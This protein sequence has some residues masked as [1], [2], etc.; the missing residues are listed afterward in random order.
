MRSILHSCGRGA[1][2]V[3][4]LGA[5][6]LLVAMTGVLPSD[7]QPGIAVS[8]QPAA[9]WSAPHV[10]GQLLVKLSDARAASVETAFAEVGVHM[11]NAIPQ[12]GLALVETSP[13]ADLAQAADVLEASAGVEWS[14]PN[15]TFSLD[16]VDSPFD[17]PTSTDSIPND[18]Y[19]LSRQDVYLSRLKMP[20]AWEYAT[21]RPEVI[22]AILDTG[23]DMTHEDLRDG[24]WTNPGEIVDNG[25]DDDGN[26]FVDDLHGWNFPDGNNRIYDDYGH[27]THVAGIAAARI[28][29]G[30]GIAGMA[31]GA[32]IMPV[33]V[34]N[35]GIGTYEDL[36]QAIV[37]ATDNGA[38][39]INMSLGATSYSR[40]EEMAVD[41]AWSHGVVPVAAAGNTGR[42]NAHYPAAHE[43][44][45]AVAATAAN[46]NLC[47]FSTRGDFVDVAAPGCP[48]WSAVPRGYSSYS[49]T[50]MATPHVSGLAALIFSL[51]PTLSPTEV[52]AVIQNN[53]DDLGDLGPDKMFGHG[54]INA[55]KSL[56]MVGSGTGPTPVP[57][58]PLPEWPAGCVDLIDDGGFEGGLGSWQ[59]SGDVAVDATRAY[60]GTQA[61]HFLGGPDAHG[62]LTHTV[63]LPAFPEEGTLWFAYRIE[64][65]DTGWGSSPEWPYDDWFTAEFRSQEGQRLAWLL[66]TGNSADSAGDGLPWDRYVYR[67]Q[68]DDFVSLRDVGPV[69]LVFAFQSDEDSDSTEFWVDAVRFCVRGQSPPRYRYYFPLWLANMGT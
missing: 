27:G 25:I 16:S 58:P 28:N 64:N 67:M 36:I 44:V 34:F 66:R 51:D 50:S 5:A 56:A 30:V 47:S 21:G 48:V 46:D 43:N 22:I 68:I 45:I 60:S 49:G 19:Y 8:S 61:A 24:I 33:D 63:T 13:G 38:R 4:V 32:T 14:E 9:D 59:A 57:P 18:P 37:Y 42:E 29:N 31:G 12:L 65:A 7:A 23:L 11:V 2:R 35:V 39:V 17:A 40:G 62:M 54:R 3:A 1:G 26:G 20:E 41:Y 55:L 53:A 6:I 52:R 10:P 69:E 15:Y